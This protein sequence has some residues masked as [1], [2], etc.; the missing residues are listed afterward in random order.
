MNCGTSRRQ[1]VDPKWQWLWLWLRLAA[2]APIQPL[3]WELPHAAGAALKCKKKK[4]EPETVS[5]HEDAGL[6]PGLA[7]WVKDPVLPQAVAI[8]QGCSS[9]RSCVAI[10]ERTSTTPNTHQAVFGVQG[11]VPMPPLPH[12]HLSVCLDSIRPRL[13]D[14][15]EHDHPV[16]G[17]AIKGTR[18]G[19]GPAQR[20]EA[21]AAPSPPPSPP[22][23]AARQGALC[24]GAA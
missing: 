16:W 17:P 14:R 11:K 6:I 2:V 4:N 1:D 9:D 10:A 23:P 7:Q 12:S 18:P 24:P 21:S 15:P 8:S 13:G 20:P 19:E 5:V 3:A 22:P